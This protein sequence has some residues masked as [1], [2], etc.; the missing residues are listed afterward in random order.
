MSVHDKVRRF[1]IWGLIVGTGLFASVKV[2]AGD[3]SCCGVIMGENCFLDLGD[4]CD[5]GCNNPN[6]PT[7]CPGTAGFCG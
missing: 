5:N 2:K 1:V 7:C 3:G 4:S 6:F